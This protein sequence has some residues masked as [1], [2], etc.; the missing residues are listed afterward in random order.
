MDGKKQR[1]KGKK[2]SKMGVGGEGG[3]GTGT[4]ENL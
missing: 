3:R 1:E 4:R 2:E